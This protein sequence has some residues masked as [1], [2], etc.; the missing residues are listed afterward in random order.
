[1]SINII[2]CCETFSL[3]EIAFACRKKRKKD[4]KF[5]LVKN[6]PVKYE[7]LLP[8]L[9]KD[10]F[11]LKVLPSGKIISQQGD[12]IKKIY[13]KENLVGKNIKNLNICDDFF[14]EYLLPIFNVCVEN[15]DSYQFSFK[16]NLHQDIKTCSFY[17]CYMPVKNSN[18]L[19]SLDIVIRT[20]KNNIKKDNVSQYIL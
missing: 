5:Q 15:P 17:P 10:F 12:Y 13:G 4:I 9:Q 6:S 7:N 11:Y 2:K 8:A 20:V 16:T 1:M 19:S 18:I 3:S 14:Q